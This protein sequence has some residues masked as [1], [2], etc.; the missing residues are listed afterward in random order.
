MCLH[1][2]AT[3]S[4]CW[5]RCHV[6]IWA[7]WKP[8]EAWRVDSH[9]DEKW[10]SL[11][12]PRHGLKQ[13]GIMLELTHTHDKSMLLTHPT[14]YLLRGSVWDVGTEALEHRKVNR[15]NAS[16]VSLCA[17][18]VTSHDDQHRWMPGLDGWKR[19]LKAFNISKGQPKR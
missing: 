7:A 12:T 14:A 11:V 8:S 9:Q 1:P 17:S 2:H 10:G 16:K 4:S 19:L 5:S 3:Q 13:Q 15:T 18:A 6:V